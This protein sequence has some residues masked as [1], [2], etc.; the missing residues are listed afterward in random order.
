VNP[1]NPAGDT[2]TICSNYPEATDAMML[3]YSN[4]MLVKS[5]GVLFGMS[6][7][8]VA[9]TGVILDRTKEY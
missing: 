9:I 5:W 8:F 2:E 4:D 1:L 7:L 3:D 6:I